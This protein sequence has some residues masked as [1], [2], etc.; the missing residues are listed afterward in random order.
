MN[1][2]RSSV[3]FAEI[4]VFV[5]LLIA[6]SYRGKLVWYALLGRTQVDMSGSAQPTQKG[7]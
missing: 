4:V 5:A 3:V 2:D 6:T 7:G 1:G